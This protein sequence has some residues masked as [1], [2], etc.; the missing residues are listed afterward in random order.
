MHQTRI[1]KDGKLERIL[2]PN[3]NINIFTINSLE[4]F[5]VSAELSLDSLNVT[6]HQGK[7]SF[8]Y[9][10]LPFAG[11]LNDN[12]AGIKSALTNGDLS[13]LFSYWGNADLNKCDSKGKKLWY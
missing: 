9:G 4:K 6:L 2:V 5:T 7:N 8:S 1:Q 11:V 13:L 10:S 12:G 3:N